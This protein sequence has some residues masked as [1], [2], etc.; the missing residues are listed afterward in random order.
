MSGIGTRFREQ[1][2]AAVQSL[3]A[4]RLRSVLTCLGIIIGVSSVITVVNLTKAL[5]ARI[6]ADVDKEGTRT[7]F[8][9]PW[10]SNKVWL[11]G[12]KVRRQPLD[13]DQ[14]R[15]VRELVPQVQIASPTYYLWG[16]SNMAKVG[17]ITR[18]VSVHAMDENGMELAN[19]DLAAGHGFTP[20]DCSTR[21]PVVILGAR[22]A[23][24]L[25][26]DEST[27]GR[28][29]TIAGQTAELIGILKKQGD[30]P[31]IPQDDEETAW[32][33][34][35]EV[36]IPFGSFKE[37]TMPWVLDNISW[38]LQVDPKLS[39]PEAE[40]QLRTALRRVRGLRGDDPDNFD[41]STNR[42][43][44]EMVEKL[45]GTLMMAAAGMVSIS[46]LVGGIG[47]MNIMLVS[48]TER[49]REIG[50]RKAL[51]ARRN[52]I[53]M[54]FLIEATLLCLA[55][56]LIGLALG[57]GL[58]NLF[59]QLLMKHLGSVPAWAI[60]AA[61]FVPAAVGIVFGLYPANKASKL[62][63]IEALRYE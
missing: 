51:G 19:L 3:W 15:E 48:V 35:N 58:G 18:R 63:P 62:D 5:E 13:R 20:T 50:I 16:R 12:K 46:L 10:I 34:D 21:A 25:G 32:G 30:I 29:F 45:S 27:L 6:M 22:I 11:S 60:I 52:N 47:V 54:Q 36:Y 61:L 7:F 28:T 41:L 9:S 56:G 1:F 42:K 40:D 17:A 49:T 44:V 55:G 57:L 43:Q 38:R 8:L 31:F 2:Q 33:P 26:L 14:I 37:L 24:D 4:H 39:V 53:L 23:Q 59:S